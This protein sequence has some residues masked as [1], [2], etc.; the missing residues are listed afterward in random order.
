MV[1]KDEI[2]NFHYMKRTPKRTDK[3]NDTQGESS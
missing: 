3:R 1:P 2:F